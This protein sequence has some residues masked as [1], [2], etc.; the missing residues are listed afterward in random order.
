MVE[1]ATAHHTEWTVVVYYVVA[2]AT[3]HSD[4][5]RARNVNADFI[6]VVMCSVKHVP[7]MLRCIHVNN[8]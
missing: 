2:E 6:G 1:N 5:L 7:V 3:T 8:E 4:W